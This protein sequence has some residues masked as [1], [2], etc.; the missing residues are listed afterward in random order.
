MYPIV[1]INDV[2]HFGDHKTYELALEAGL[3]EALKLIK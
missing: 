1:C 2:G 3:I